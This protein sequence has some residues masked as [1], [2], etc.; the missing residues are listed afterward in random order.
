M[1]KYTLFG[2]G[3]AAAVL[4]AVSGW[5]FATL[6]NT[7]IAAVILVNALVV[8]ALA[9]LLLYVAKRAD[10]ARSADSAGQS[11]P[12][13]GLSAAA[14]PATA[15]ADSA[16]S[17]ASGAKLSVLETVTLIGFLLFYIGAVVL[18]I[19]TGDWFYLAIALATLAASLVVNF[20]KLKNYRSLTARERL[21]LL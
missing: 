19:T 3:I 4:A 5:L 16:A 13:A 1:N 7:V 17:S 18:T 21:D 12:A 20:N 9:G 2:L 14:E 11:T 15:S 6:D 10:T 8:L